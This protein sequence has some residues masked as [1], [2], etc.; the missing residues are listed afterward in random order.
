MTKIE[1]TGLFTCLREKT[2]NGLTEEE[3]D[4]MA[5]EFMETVRRECD[6][7]ED[8]GEEVRFLTDVGNRLSYWRGCREKPGDG[9][10]NG[11]VFFGGGECLP[12]GGRGTSVGKGTGE[13]S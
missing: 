11:C 7:R 3:I 8:Y 13:I 5:G 12:A 9:E 10:W 1:Q 2:W 4:R 6:E